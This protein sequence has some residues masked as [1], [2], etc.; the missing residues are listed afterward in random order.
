MAI[1]DRHGTVVFRGSDEDDPEGTTAGNNEIEVGFDR[2]QPLPVAFGE[3]SEDV[4]YNFD[5]LHLRR[6]DILVV[7]KPVYAADAYGDDLQ[8]DGDYQKMLKIL[9]APFAWIYKTYKRGTA[10]SDGAFE[11]SDQA[12]DDD[13]FE[14][15][16]PLQVALPSPPSISPITNGL[17][18]WELTLRAS[19]IETD[20][21]D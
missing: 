9:T 7:L 19:Q 1:W 4:G 17:V 12:G 10:H 11:W 20:P 5:G 21:L 6:F 15:K 8:L 16:V 18:R 3:T 13:F 2:L 14:D